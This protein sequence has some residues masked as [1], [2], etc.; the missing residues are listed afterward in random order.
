MDFLDAS[1]NNMATQ[2]FD[3]TPK[4]LAT[5]QSIYTNF[6]CNIPVKDISKYKVKYTSEP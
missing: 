1:D 4:S 6:V 2:T 3:L 5:T